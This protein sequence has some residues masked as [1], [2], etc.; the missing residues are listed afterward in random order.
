[1]TQPVQIG[2]CAF[3]LDPR[4]RWYRAGGGRVRRPS[5]GEWAQAVH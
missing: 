4:V 3:G 1:M 2:S 5:V